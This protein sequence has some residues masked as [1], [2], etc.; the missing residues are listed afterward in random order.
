[1]NRRF[2]PFIRAIYAQ[3]PGYA[4]TYAG[5]ILALVV[6]GMSANQGWWSYLPL[7]LAMVII[8]SYFLLG[9]I[10]VV[11]QVHG[12]TGLNPHHTLFDMGRLQPT[13]RLVF[14]DLGL[15]H[16]PVEIANRLTTGQVVVVDVYNPHWAA[17]QSLIRWRS[18]LPQTPNDPRLLWRNGSIN[19]LPLPN[20][21]VTT[22]MM[23]QV[24]SEFWQRG[25]QLE[26]LRE[27]QRILSPDGR[28]LLAEPVRSQNTWLTLGPTAIKRKL[29]QYW[30]DLLLEAGFN[31]RADEGKGGLIHYFRADRL[32]AGQGRQLPLDLII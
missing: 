25:D 29:P 19:L 30:R 17:G 14:I 32:A 24:L 27:V 7:S 22:V 4:L 15:R 28:L 5:I 13:D 8:L 31:I 16:R 18:R 3:W 6:L 20:A 26:L 12:R 10:Y 9:N 1:M 2:N 11:S 21:S 23:C